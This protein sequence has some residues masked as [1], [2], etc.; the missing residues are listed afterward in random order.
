M[1]KQLLLLVMMLLP[2][3]ANANESGTCGESVTWN[4]EEATGTL[5]ILGTGP[6]ED[7]MGYREGITWSNENNPFKE[8]GSKVKTVIINEGVSSI[9][10]GAFVHCYDLSSISIPNSV[11]SIGDVSFNGCSKLSEISISDN[12]SYI[13][14][15]AFVGCSSLVSVNIPNSTTTIEVNAFASCSSLT[16]IEIPESVRASFTLFKIV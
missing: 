11:T 9:G 15:E 3:L 2:I 4:F 1:K 12:V 8:I 7:Y 16:S 5:T 6:M 10:G 14:A 13:G